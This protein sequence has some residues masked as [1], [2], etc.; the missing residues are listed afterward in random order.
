MAEEEIV[1]GR[2][3]RM[4]DQGVGQSQGDRE[5]DSCTQYVIVVPLVVVEDVVLGVIAE[6]EEPSQ[7]HCHVECQTGCG[8]RVNDSIHFHKITVAELLID[9]GEIVVGAEADNQDA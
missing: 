7:A 6:G 1:D 4:S 3:A 5:G 8:R 2:S 9:G